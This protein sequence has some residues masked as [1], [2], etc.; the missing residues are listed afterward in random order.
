MLLVEALVELDGDVYEG[1]ADAL[2]H[3]VDVGV[4]VYLAL[5]ALDEARVGLALLALLGGENGV[6]FIELRL[7]LGLEDD[8]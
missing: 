4:L 6:D 8:E 3:R 1:V 7:R 2:D 5:D